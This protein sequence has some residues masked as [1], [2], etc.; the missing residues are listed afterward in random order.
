MG[1]LMRGEIGGGNV[2][3][4]VWEMGECKDLFFFCRLCGGR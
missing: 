1:L 3:E 2:W 4:C